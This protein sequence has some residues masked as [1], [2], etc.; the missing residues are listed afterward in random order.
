MSNVEIDNTDDFSNLLQL[1][2]NQGFYGEKFTAPL[3][4]DADSAPSNG[5][6][7]I[8]GYMVD[9]DEFNMKMIDSSGATLH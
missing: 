9:D 6:E 3:V 2:C 4:D 8:I 7:T 5:H 1:G